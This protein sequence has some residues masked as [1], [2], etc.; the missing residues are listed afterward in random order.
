MDRITNRLDGNILKSKLLSF[1]KNYFRDTF[2]NNS[3][4]MGVTDVKLMSKTL[5]NRRMVRLVRK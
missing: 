1:G 4:Q 3:E 5:R 2:Y